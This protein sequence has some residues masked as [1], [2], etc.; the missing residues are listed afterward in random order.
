M[1]GKKAEGEMLDQENKMM[2]KFKALREAGELKE[3]QTHKEETR[4]SKQVIVMRTDLE[5]NAGKMVAQGAH[6]SLKVI[7]DQMYSLQDGTGWG[8]DF[9]D[10]Q[11][12]PLG[13]WILGIFTKVT[14]KCKSEE[15]LM[16]LHKAATDAGI[17][18]SLIIDKILSEQHEKPIYTCI[19]IGP[20]WSED[21]DKISGKLRLLQT[22]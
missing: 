3:N 14:L 7:L 13:D 2:A 1:S 18:C 9:G 11:H 8:L 20:A 12:Q 6:A 19:A 5:M 16:N 10:M 4:Q 22:L 21:I 15:K 17:P